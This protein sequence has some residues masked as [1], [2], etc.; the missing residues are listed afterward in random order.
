MASIHIWVGLV[1]MHLTR[2]CGTL[3]PTLKNSTPSEEL[4]NRLSNYKQIHHLYGKG[5]ERKSATG[6]GQQAGALVAQSNAR[7]YASTITASI[8]SRGASVTLA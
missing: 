5:N 2:Q 6:F 3:F 8:L 4:K 7:A 1:F